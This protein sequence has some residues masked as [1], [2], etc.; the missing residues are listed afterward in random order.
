M[1]FECSSYSTSS[2]SARA[3]P[4]KVAASRTVLVLGS[5]VAAGQAAHSG[6]GW[7]DLLEA[8]LIKHYGDGYRLLNAAMGGANTGATA[9]YA[10]SVGRDL[11]PDI[12][13]IALGLANEGL[14]WVSEER[15]VSKLSESFL[16]GLRSIADVVRNRWGHDITIVYGGV[17]PFGLGEGGP[18]YDD[19]Q[20]RALR[21]VDDAMSRWK[22]PVIPFLKTS[23]DDLCR[24][25]PGTAVDVG[26]P[27]NIGHRRMFDAID[28][29]IFAPD[30][31]AAAEHSPFVARASIP[32]ARSLWAFYGL[33]TTASS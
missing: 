28:I 8:A 2:S 13:I 9:L 29:S 6:G 1:T 23:G 19:Q 33:E 16:D 11:N 20:R 31:A 4:M 21:K 7:A 24:W 3:L 32:N 14:P 26:H 5:S 10:Q 15:E 25:H 17:Y 22:E 27:N 12:V 18:C 30:A